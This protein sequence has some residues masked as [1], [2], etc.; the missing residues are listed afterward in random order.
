MIKIGYWLASELHD[1]GKLVRDAR[2]AEELGFDHALISDHYLPW[3]D[4]QGHSPF[5]WSVIGG[6]AQATERIRAHSGYGGAVDVRRQN[7]RR[8]RKSNWISGYPQVLGSLSNPHPRYAELLAFVARG[9]LRPARLVTR[10]IALEDVNDT[11]DRMT[12]FDTVGFEVI[13]RFT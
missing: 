6:I 10:E 13:T 1:P 8:D 11:L 2:R 5:V 3:L 9:K 4:E 7:R 12:R